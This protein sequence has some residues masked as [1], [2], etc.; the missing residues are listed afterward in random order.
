MKKLKP[1]FS[2]TPFLMLCIVLLTSCENVLEKDDLTAISEKSVWN[3]KDLATQ[4]VNYLYMD[5]PQWPTNESNASDDGI[6]SNELMYG[7][8]TIES[9]DF[10]PYYN[11]RSINELLE[12]IGTGTIPKS[13]QDLLKGQALFIRANLYFKL[14][15]KYGGVPLVLKTQAQTDDLKVSRN[16]TSECITQIIK[17]LDDSSALLPESWSSADAGRITK[18]AALAFKGRVLLH[19]A[20][21]QFDPT[22][23]SSARWT[24][25][26]NANKTAQTHLIAQGKGLMP[27]YKQLWFVEGN[28]NTEAI[29]TT[30]YINPGRTHSRDAYVRPLD[31]AQNFTGSDQPT[32]SLVNAYPMKNGLAITDPASGYNPNA[33]WLNR[34]PRFDADI[35]YN[36]NLWELSGKTG[37]IQWSFLGAQLTGNGI[38]G[39]YCKK[40]VNEALKPNETIISGTDWIEIRFAEVILNLAESANETGKSAEAYDILKLIRKRA[41]ITAGGNDLYGL[42]ASMNKLQMRTAILNERR[43]EFSFEGKRASDLRR[44]RMYE[45]LNGT[46][47]KG[48]AINLI[49]YNKAGFLAAYAAGTVNLNTNYTTYFNDVIIN[50]DLINSINYKP[51]YYFYAIPIRHL[52]LNANL[53][54]TL[55]WDGGT[56]DPLQ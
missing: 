25:A 54:Q 53:Q 8:L 34:D 33:Y 30:R 56:F 49:G 48:L 50:L 7:Q 40:A 16:K 2:F 46:K 24:A 47:R 39:F 45:T 6:G 4:Y 11:I 9:N 41:G 26:Y 17:D 18:G 43:I 37:R 1:I 29:M 19:Y 52:Q 12:Q 36:G 5:L 51:E 44:R 20:S 27:N 55:G 10:W 35:A 13:D 22:Q 14:V 38:T 21:E 28:A 32:L 42:T 31:E 15:S 23:S 3:S